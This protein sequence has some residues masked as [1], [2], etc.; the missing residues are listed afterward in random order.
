M[1]KIK[2]KF[3]LLRTKVKSVSTNV[4]ELKKQNQKLK[5]SNEELLSKMTVVGE[6]N[7]MAKRFIKERDIIKSR[8]KNIVES[9]ERAGI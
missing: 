2:N 5:E 6:E 8:I 7:K 4:S 3:G 9:I 1:D